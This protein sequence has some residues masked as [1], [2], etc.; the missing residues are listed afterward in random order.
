MSLRLKLLY[1]FDFRTLQILIEQINLSDYLDKLLYHMN[2]KLPVKGFEKV[3][4]F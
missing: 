4:F 3:Y 1:L 2:Y